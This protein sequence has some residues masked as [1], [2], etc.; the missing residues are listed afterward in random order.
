[1][2]M[3]FQKKS[4]YAQVCK[5]YIKE[6]ATHGQSIELYTCTST[7]RT[8]KCWEYIGEASASVP[9]QHNVCDA[10]KEL[11]ARKTSKKK[12][13]KLYKV[14]FLQLKKESTH[15]TL[16]SWWETCLPE[17]AW[18][19]CQQA[20]S[21]CQCGL[22]LC[23]PSHSDPSERNIWCQYVWTWSEEQGSFLS[24][25]VLKQNQLYTVCV[26]R[27]LSTHTADF[28]VNNSSNVKAKWIKLTGDTWS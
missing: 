24:Q 14:Y 20:E 28:I 19:G 3:I 7:K 17:G 26:P 6:L 22:G 15:L 12:I 25:P 2:F 18:L 11:N 1:M 27:I 5:Q 13:R 16:P 9:M 21:R 23:H 10:C 8:S 4:S